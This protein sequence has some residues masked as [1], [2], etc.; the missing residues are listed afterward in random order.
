MISLLLLPL[1]ALQVDIPLKRL[2]VGSRKQRHTIAQGFYFSDAKIS[3][4]LKRDHP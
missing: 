2:N 1:D 3:A 4:K